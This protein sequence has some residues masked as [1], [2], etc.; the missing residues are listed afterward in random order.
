MESLGYMLILTR[1]NCSLLNQ[2]NLIYP[3]IHT[4]LLLWDNLCFSEWLNL[5]IEINIHQSVCMYHESAMSLQRF[6]LAYVCAVL[7]SKLLWVAVAAAVVI[8]NRNTNRRGVAV[9]PIQS[10]N[11]GQQEIAGMS[12]FEIIPTLSRTYSEQ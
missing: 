3:T 7:T 11:I 1:K 12:F 4:Y 5:S 9:G 8:P 6:C 10:K 2:G